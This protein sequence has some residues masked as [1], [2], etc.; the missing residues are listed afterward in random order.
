MDVCG[1]FVSPTV[2]S[3]S[4]YQITVE[5][6]GFLV[7]FYADT[8]ILVLEKYCCLTVCSSVVSA[9]VLF[10]HLTKSG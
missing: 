9:Q 2:R 7:S 6:S 4:S 3:Q 10:E 1:W 5:N 8:A